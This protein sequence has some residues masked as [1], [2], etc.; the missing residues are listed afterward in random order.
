MGWEDEPQSPTEHTP[1]IP[2]RWGP[3]FCSADGERPR[4]ALP[5]LHCEHRCWVGFSHS[6]APGRL[7]WPGGLKFIFSNRWGYESVS[8]SECNKKSSSKATQAVCALDPSWPSPQ[9][10]WLNR[11][12][13]LALGVITSVYVSLSSSVAGLCSG[14]RAFSW[15]P[16]HHIALGTIPHSRWGCELT[17]RPGCSMKVFIAQLCL[18]LVQPLCLWDSPGKNAGVGCCSLLQGIFLTQRSNPGLLPCRQIF[19]FFL[20]IWAPGKPKI[21]INNI[22]LRY[23]PGRKTGVGSH[24]LL[25]GVF[26]TQGRNLGLLCCRWILYHEPPGELHLGVGWSLRACYWLCFVGDQLC[27]PLSLLTHCWFMPRQAFSA[28]LMSRGAGSRVL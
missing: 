3:W 2:V 6:W 12:T 11:A 4:A 9:V 10:S 15:S 28:A 24:S 16:S 18:T 27:L 7:P 20:T 5:V 17:P 1:S 13:G 21:S 8:L 19:F 14:F 22:S 23:S 25:H 26:P